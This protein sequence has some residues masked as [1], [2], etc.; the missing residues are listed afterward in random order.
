MK[1]LKVFIFNALVLTVT[2]LILR[3]IL[4]FFGVYIS[5]KIGQEALGIFQLIMSVYVFGITLAASGINLTS[6]RIVSEELACNNVYGAKQAAK[7]CTF[8][9]LI[10][11]IVAGLILAFFSDFIVDF[12]FHNKVN[13]SIVYMICIALPFTSMSSAICGYFSAVRRVYK[14]ASRSI[15]RTSY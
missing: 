11:G 9:S 14:S 2:T 3:V 12:C 15:C 10:C 6:T 8:I 13:K 5:N 7:R 4:T 1:R